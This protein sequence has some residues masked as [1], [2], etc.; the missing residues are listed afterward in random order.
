MV[1]HR[2]YLLFVTE[3]K[4]PPAPLHLRQVI[5][6]QCGRYF[7]KDIHGQFNSMSVQEFNTALDRTNRNKDTSIVRGSLVMVKPK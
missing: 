6:T 1:V 2:S 5:S 3:S 4:T 7:R